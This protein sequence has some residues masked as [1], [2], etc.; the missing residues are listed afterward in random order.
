MEDLNTAA[1]GACRLLLR[2]MARVGSDLACLV[3]VVI[4]SRR[5]LVPAGPGAG[6]QGMQ[7][8]LAPRCSVWLPQARREEITTS[9]RCPFL[10]ILERCPGAG[11]ARAFQ[12]C[13]GSNFSTSPGSRPK[14]QMAG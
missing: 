2:R 7:F 12:H 5:G 1:C 14:P 13:N 6:V 8:R 3:L 9:T 11:G 10:V 4:S